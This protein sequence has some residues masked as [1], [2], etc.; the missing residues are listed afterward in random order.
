MFV[1]LQT[2]GLVCL[3]EVRSTGVVPPQSFL[4][5]KVF[6]PCTGSLWVPLE[7]ASIS[8]TRWSKMP[9]LPPQRS[10]RGSRNPQKGAV[11]TLAG[12]WPCSSL[13]CSHEAAAPSR[14]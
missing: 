13:P 9:V 10:L 12:P 5:G 11:I 1:L 6:P 3:G 8:V 7:M 2:P 4:P 14:E